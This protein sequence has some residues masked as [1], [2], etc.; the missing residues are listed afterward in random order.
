LEKQYRIL[1]S[2]AERCFKTKSEHGRKD[3]PC[4]VAF[5]TG[6]SSKNPINE[7]QLLMIRSRLKS[8][9]AFTIVELLVS[10]SIIAVLIALILPAVQQAREA[11]RRTTCRNNLRQIG[12]A[13]HNYNDSHNTFPPGWIPFDSQTLRP[14][15]R[16]GSWAWSAF[17]LP[18]LDQSSLYHMLGVSSAQDPPPPGAN[19]D[20]ALHVFLCPTDVGG[21]QSGYGLWR[22]GAALSV[23]GPTNPDDELLVGY[24]KSNYIGVRGKQAFRFIDLNP[25]PGQQG[26]FEASSRTKLEKITDGT[27]NTFAVGER[28]TGRINKS[29]VRGGVWLRICGKFWDPSGGESVACSCGDGGASGGSSI[30]AKSITGSTHTPLNSVQAIGCRSLETEAFD[31]EGFSSMHSSGAMFLLV[32]GSVRFVNQAVDLETY[33]NLGS[34]NGGEVVGEF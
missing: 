25:L 27:S 8:R 9:S 29:C 11:A 21:N 14:A 26:L 34:I 5:K 13:L 4:F 30:D 1:R 3:E 28:S 24:A 6:N 22:F 16:G 2:C 33:R 10:I 19:N 17:L 12:F 20:I 32:D 23:L 15:D 18:Y 7:W 31:L